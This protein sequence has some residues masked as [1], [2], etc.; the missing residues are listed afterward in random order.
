MYIDFK[1]TF[2]LTCHIRQQAPLPTVTVNHCTHGQQHQYTVNVHS[3][4]LPAFL[5]DTCTCPR[6]ARA[7]I[8]IHNNLT[9]I[10]QNVNYWAAHQ[11]AEFSGLLYT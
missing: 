6:H 10:I 8:S 3:I 5:S 11:P 7:P 4:R 2:H 9:P 1:V